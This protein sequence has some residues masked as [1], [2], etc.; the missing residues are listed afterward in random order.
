MFIVQVIETPVKRECHDESHTFY[1]G[2]NVYAVTLR[3]RPPILALLLF[4]LSS[5]FNGTA[6]NWSCCFDVSG[7]LMGQ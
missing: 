5:V 1:L 3:S 2:N 6:I 7:C 4:A